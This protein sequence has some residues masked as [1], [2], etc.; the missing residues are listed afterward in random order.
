MEEGREQ[1]SDFDLFMQ[2]QSQQSQK[3]SIDLL[4]LQYVCVLFFSAGW[5][6]GRWF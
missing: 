3:V 5:F 1:S 4:G 6:A 2:N